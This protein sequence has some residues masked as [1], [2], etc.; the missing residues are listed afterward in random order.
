MLEDGRIAEQG[1]HKELM[2]QDGFFRKLYQLQQDAEGMSALEET[3][4]PMNHAVSGSRE[5]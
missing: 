3:P 1:T 2:A 4:L 5:V